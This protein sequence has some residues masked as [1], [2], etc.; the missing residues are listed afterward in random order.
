MRSGAFVSSRMTRVRSVIACVSVGLGLEQIA[1][2][3][4]HELNELYQATLERHVAAPAPYATEAAL[5]LD[6]QG[7]EV[8]DMSRRHGKAPSSP[9][10]AHQ[11]RRLCVE[12]L[13]SCRLSQKPVGSGS[14]I[15][16]RCTLAL[17]RW[18]E[19]GHE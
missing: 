10:F 13:T 3:M 12:K 8:S 14:F 11:V 4:A 17:C 2:A 1:P 19:S 5:L 9:E 16:R 6:K 18:C 7:N 15:M